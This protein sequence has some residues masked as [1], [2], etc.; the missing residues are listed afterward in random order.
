MK[1][2]STL[3][4]IKRWELDQKRRALAD[5]E[6]LHQE[7]R[8]RAAAL[9]Q[10]LAAEQD[11]ARDDTLRFA[12]AAYAR[13]A[14]EQREALEGSLADLDQQIASARDEVA[15][16]YGEVKRYERVSEI[17]AAKIAAD[18]RRRETAV[19]DEVAGL[20]HRRRSQR[21]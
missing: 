15:E 11:A 3:I 2:I 6:G 10:R 17:N 7:L 12:Y 9:E 20:Q 8:E 4:R 19:L 13:R 5:L 21:A 18:I 1:S 14:I 16:L